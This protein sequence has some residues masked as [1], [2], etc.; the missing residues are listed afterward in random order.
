VLGLLRDE[1]LALGLVEVGRALDREV[2]ALGRAGGP[3]D[4]LAV[5]T[6]Q[7]GNLVARMLDRRLGRPAEHVVAARRVAVVRGEERHHRLDDARIDLRRGVV[8]HEDRK[9]YFDS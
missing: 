3:D 1:V 2:V 9:F 5:A 6:D 8:I 4:L 7:R